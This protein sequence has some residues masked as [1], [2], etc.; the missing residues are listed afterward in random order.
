M[1]AP[2]VRPADPPAL[3][4]SD[5]HDLAKLWR[6]HWKRFDGGIGYAMLFGAEPFGMALIAVT[7]PVFAGIL[8]VIFMM[9]V[10]E[11]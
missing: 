9:T 11:T 8:F 7:A 10:I 5:N 1:L 6:G 2:V 4:A 3:P